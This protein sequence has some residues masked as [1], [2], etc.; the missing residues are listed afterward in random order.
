MTNVQLMNAVKQ[1]FVALAAS[2]LVAYYYERA[3]GLEHGNDFSDQDRLYGRDKKGKSFYTPPYP[4]LL[5]AVLAAFFISKGFFAGLSAFFTYTADLMLAISIYYALLIFLPVLRRH[6]SARACAE[7]WLIP[8]IVIVAKYYT[9][10][11]A[12]S[13]RFVLY[14]PQPIFDLLLP[15]WGIGFLAI[16]AGYILSH[17][18]FRRRIKKTAVEETDGHVL[19]LWKQEL[20]RLDYKRPVRLLRC[21]AARAPFSMGNTKWTRVTVLPSQSYT[22]EEL[23]LIFRH[24]LHHIRR[25]DSNTKLY[26]A[27]SNAL[28]W[29]HPFVWIASREASRDMELACDEL[30]LECSDSAERKLYADLLL[31]TAGERRG[32]TTCLS[33]SAKALRCRL[34]AVL[35]PR[36]RS[37]GTLFLM[38]LVFCSILSYDAFAISTQRTTVGDELLC[39]SPKFDCVLYTS[40]DEMIRSNFGTYDEQA[41]YSYIASLPIECLS[42]T[43]IYS[44][45]ESNV[46]RLFLSAGPNDN[47]CVCIYD[48]G[49]TLYDRD[50]GHSTFYYL[51]EPVDWAKIEAF[52]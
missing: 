27:F 45:L 52:L 11:E 34:H 10:A 51:R 36:K 19:A 35:H 21:E 2:C 38:L 12:S 37:S 46:P 4:F 6:I 23:T 29:F 16:F 41:L 13:V 48:N 15:V 31:N 17:L 49:V 18:I 43:R 44:D 20:E 24:E 3:W 39:D 26:F 50:E 42:G 5:L 8:Y 9:T 25:C 40:A 7:L 30:V 32:F 47:L 1:L 14:I 22:D 33:A 28:L